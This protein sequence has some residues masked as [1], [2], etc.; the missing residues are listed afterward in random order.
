LFLLVLAGGEEN[1]QYYPA[2]HP[3]HA[4]IYQLF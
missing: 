1:D 4:A 3:V 2:E